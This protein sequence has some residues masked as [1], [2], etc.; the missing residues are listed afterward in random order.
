MRLFSQY[1]TRLGTQYHI[2]ATELL[3]HEHWLVT[4]PFV[5]TLSDGNYVCVPTG[6]LTDG[7]S[8]PRLLWNLI[9]PWG[10][11]GQASVMH[12]YLCE[13]SKISDGSKYITIDRERVDKIFLEGLTALNVSYTKRSLLYAGV[14]A[15]RKLTNPV[16]PSVTKFKALLEETIMQNYAR[17]GSFSLTPEQML[18]FNKLKT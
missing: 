10:E 15:Y 3:G 18:Y 14:S 4:E 9:P 8:V 1:D 13:Y 5:Y 12:D 16:T 17:T 7:A 11:H 2:Q 6:F